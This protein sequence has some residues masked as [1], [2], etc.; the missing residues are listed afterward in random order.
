MTTRR[1]VAITFGDAQTGSTKFRIK[2]YENYLLDHGIQ[3]ETFSQKDISDRWLEEMRKADAIINQ[4]CLL[5]GRW[6]GKILG[7]RKPLLFDFD[8]S[9]Y[10]RP[11]KPFSFITKIR[12]K[13]RLKRWLK[14]ASC[15]TTANDYL[16][17]YAA[18]YSDSVKI[19]PMSL[20]THA[21]RPVERRQDRPGLVIGWAG[22]PSNLHHLEKIEPSLAS[23]LDQF[24]HVSLAVFSG[25]RPKLSCRYDYVP[26][27]EGAEAAFVQNIDIGLLPLI[28]EEFSKGKSPIKA[29]QYLACG[30]PVVG[31]FYG[32]TRELLNAGN[33][34]PV[35]APQEWVPALRR[36]LTDSSLREQMGRQGRQDIVQGHCLKRTG[37]ILKDTLLQLIEEGR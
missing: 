26:F 20:D 24:P 33:S 12:V 27:Q 9:I 2:Q 14:T 8:D 21:W 23:I 35:T 32:A 30:I 17:S 4:K 11:G 13:H 16:R 7:L 10:T 36:L 6:A 22:A 5:G 1:V 37:E 29:I 34:L 18:G 15:V 31:N 25:Q 19:V 28:D 3:M